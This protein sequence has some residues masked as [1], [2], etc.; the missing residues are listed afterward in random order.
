MGVGLKDNETL[1]KKKAHKRVLGD[2]VLLHQQ[3]LE[4]KIQFYWH[5]KGFITR[6]E[7]VWKLN[8]NIYSEEKNE[9][10][11]GLGPFSV[12][13]RKK[14]SVDRKNLLVLTVSPTFETV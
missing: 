3:I 11:A 1:I 8:N 7:T 12:P 2:N 13:K 14:K 6:T 10:S 4:K 9:P 5:E